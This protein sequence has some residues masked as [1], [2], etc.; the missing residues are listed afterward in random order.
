MQ[1]FKNALTV[2]LF[3][4]SI[5]IF[6]PIANV[7]ADDHRL[8]QLFIHTYIHSNGSATISEY[9][10]AH[11][12]EGTENYDVIENLGKS[13]I[14]SFEVGE[15]GL[16][17]EYIEDW[18]INATREEKTFKNS[19]LKTDDGYELVWGI[20]E[21]GHHEYHIRYV[22]TDFIKQL[23]DSQILFWRFINDEMNTPPKEIVIVIET[24]RP[25]SNETEKI[26]GF[27]FEGNV[28]FEDGVVVARNE[29]PLDTSNY[30]TILI[31][32]PDGEFATG[33]ILNK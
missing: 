13:Q 30:A 16:L 7:H 29:E 25:L 11:L 18:N 17:Y 26:W 15:H 5:I 24:E 8:D 20:G 22:V 19:I 33:D 3:I 14:F 27:G 28:D 21:Y 10:N 1:K 31:Q 12:T 4:F 6:I 23:E 32:F 9:R 2:F